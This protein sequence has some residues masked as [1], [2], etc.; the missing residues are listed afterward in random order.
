MET[1][2]DRSSQLETENEGWRQAMRFESSGDAIIGESP[3][4]MRVLEQT[5]L[6]ATTEA[7]VLLEGESG[8][9]KELF[10]QRIHERS[11]R[12]RK[13]MVRVNCAAIPADLFESEFF[14][15]V[16]GAF[17]GASKD[18]LGRFE[19]ANGGT[20]FLDEVGEIPLEL[21]GKL[22]RVLQEGSFERVG[23]EQT[24]RA[25]VRVVAATNRNL[26]AAVREG[27]FREDLYY[28][29][30]VFP[31]RLPALRERKRDLPLLVPHLLAKAARKM[32]LP[33][34]TLEAAQI[35]RM[36][37]YN[38]PGNIRELQ[39]ELERAL[40]LSRNGAIT[41]R[42]PQAYKR[43]GDGLPYPD[44]HATVLSEQ[45]WLRLQRENMQ[46]AIA[47]S[48]GRVDGPGGAA[49]LLGLRPT[50]L[51]SRLKKHGL[52]S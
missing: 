21:Q 13:A 45:D 30:S 48:G 9:G 17:T 8:T 19:L 4:L 37:A 52:Q 15:H 32:G 38:W 22:L 20:L 18:R 2:R 10:A 43:S 44:G 6:V 42:P 36:A 26:Q 24:R 5:D 35:D 49:E 11:S 29:L 16:K 27:R 46:R 41:L 25:N 33:L 34:P 14:G 1:L 28:R 23:E 39:N 31:I 50:T 51:R 47:A 12:S 40:I 3:A 7:T